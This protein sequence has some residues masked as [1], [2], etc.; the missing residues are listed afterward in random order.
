MNDK[1][2]KYIEELPEELRDKARQCKSLE[3]LNELIDENDVEL[4]EEA[5]GMVAGGGLCASE[6]TTIESYVFEAR[7]GVNELNYNGLSV[8]VISI[9][10]D[11]KHKDRITY[12][13][14]DTDW[15]DHNITEAEFNKIKSMCPAAN[16]RRV[17]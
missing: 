8:D 4:S 11:Q 3:E 5:L 7:N 10:Q 1:L 6:V 14:T 9:K 2:K 16:W 15:Q 12:V 13:F 17:F